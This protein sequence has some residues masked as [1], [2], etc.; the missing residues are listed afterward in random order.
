MAQFTFP[1]LFGETKLMYNLCNIYSSS[2]H[3]R[4]SVFWHT[5][6]A[7]LMISVT[8]L[9]LPFTTG[10]QFFGMQSKQYSTRSTAPKFDVREFKS[11]LRYDRS[12][13]LLLSIPFTTFC[14]SVWQV[15]R[16]YWKR[17][18]MNELEEQTRQPPVTIP[19]E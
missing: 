7:I 19:F 1:R 10:R 15:Y 3:Y 2:F 8:F 18:L 6:Q 13:M 5:K 9:V 17:G 12:F 14:L 11:R 16:L 4:T